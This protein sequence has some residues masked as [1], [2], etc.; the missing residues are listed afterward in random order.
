MQVGPPQLK[1]GHFCRF[2]AE[3]KINKPICCMYPITR[4]WTHSIAMQCLQSTRLP[5]LSSIYRIILVVKSSAIIVVIIIFITRTSR[6]SVITLYLQGLHSLPFSLNPV[7][8]S[9]RILFTFICNSLISVA[10]AA[11]V[12]FNWFNLCTLERPKCTIHVLSF[13]ISIKTILSKVS[14]MCK[15]ACVFCWRAP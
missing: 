14:A 12:C 6:I 10:H 11:C 4:W 13:L 5:W 1:Q 3:N 2:P 7:T 9:E 15:R 8:L